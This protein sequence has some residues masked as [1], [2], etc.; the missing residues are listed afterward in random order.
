M[1][2]YGQLAE[3]IDSFQIWIAC[4]VAD[5]P[6][7]V[8]AELGG[9]GFGIGAKAIV[10]AAL[11]EGDQELIGNGATEGLPSHLYVAIG[12]DGNWRRNG[13]L[14]QR[15]AQRPAAQDIPGRKFGDA[16]ELDE[17]IFGGLGEFDAIYRRVHSR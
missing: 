9:E 4:E 6:M 8:E 17:L 14:R 7:E 10:V 16:L 1:T 13:G 11:F 15:S 2:G 5:A 12:G 3:V